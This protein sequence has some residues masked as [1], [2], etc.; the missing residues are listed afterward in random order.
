MSLFRI[1]HIFVFSF[2]V[3]VYYSSFLSFNVNN[4]GTCFAFVQGSVPATNRH[5]TKSKCYDMAWKSQVT[6]SLSS[7]VEDKMTKINHSVTFN[8]EN[9]VKFLVNIEDQTRITVVQEGNEPTTFWAISYSSSFFHF[10]ILSSVL[11]SVIDLTS[12]RIQQHRRHR[13]SSD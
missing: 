12:I 10:L 11:S 9:I 5:G 3:L 1:I 6:T 13:L 4:I 8:L 2:F 7:F